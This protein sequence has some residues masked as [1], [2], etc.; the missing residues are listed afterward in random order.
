MRPFCCA[1]VTL[2][3]V[4]IGLNKPPQEECELM[5]KEEDVFDTFQNLLTIPGIGFVNATNIIAS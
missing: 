2:Y 1:F 3:V 5:S 4:N